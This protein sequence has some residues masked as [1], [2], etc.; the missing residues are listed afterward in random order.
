MLDDI[1][2]CVSNLGVSDTDI[3]YNLG[4][5]AGTQPVIEPNKTLVE[6]PVNADVQE[7]YNRLESLG[8]NLTELKPVLE[9]GDE[10]L[11]ISCAGS[12]KTTALI[13][14][15]IKGMISGEYMKYVDIPTMQGGVTKCLVPKKIFIGTFLKTG[16]KELENA[17][18]RWVKKLRISGLSTTS[19][20]FGTLHSEFYDALRSMG[21]GINISKDTLDLLESV[22]VKYDIHNENGYGY[23]KKS[24]NAEELRDL[25]CIITYARN[26]LDDKRYTHPL[27][28]T[29]GL[30]EPMLKLILN[31]FAALRQ[32]TNKM[33]FEDLQELLYNSMRQYPH[34]CEYLNS[35]YDVIMLDEFQDTSQIQYEILKEYM[36]NKQFFVI[37]DDDQTIYSW[38]GSD[39]EIINSR[40]EADF[41]PNVTM[42][43][44]NYRCSC[45][46]LDCVAPSIKNNT[47]RHSKVLQACKPGGSVTV[48]DNSDVNELLKEVIQVI[49]NHKTASILSRTNADLLAPA[50]LLELQGNI[51]YTLSKGVTMQNALCHNVFG[52]IPLIL[53]QRSKHFISLF[54]QVLPYNAAR[55]ATTLAGILNMPAVKDNIFTLSADDLKYSVP[56]LW[57]TLIKPLR[58]AK[59]KSDKYTY[60]IYLTVL[61][62]NGY[63]SDTTYCKKAR[64]F[65]KFV[66][67]LVDGSTVCKSL[68]L[69]ELNEMFNSVLPERIY[70]HTHTHDKVCP[71]SI[72][73]VHEA[74]GK[75][76]DSVFIWNAIDGTFPYI[77]GSH[78]ITKE[79]YD[80]ERRIFYIAMTRARDSVTLFTD[81][82]SESP[83]LIECDH[84][85]IGEVHTDN[86][87]SET[88][89]PKQRFMP[90]KQKKDLSLV[91]SIVHERIAKYLS[92]DITKDNTDSYAL[93]VKG[94]NICACMESSDVLV[95]D[96]VSAYMSYASDAKTIAEAD[97]RKFVD[98][99]FTKRG[100]DYINEQLDI[101]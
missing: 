95:V 48:Y 97:V 72:T 38:R 70:N 81:S 101:V 3:G 17:F 12:G 54:K 98:T 43:S 78:E 76:W 5:H 16:A 7:F 27:M 87:T 40:F 20:T 18:Y 37:G 83:F 25:S 65:I 55:E 21:V 41:H 28:S 14:K 4:D 1:E 79:E 73:T 88:N 33:D 30:T 2:N 34:I 90:D 85:K 47:G 93:G 49:N 39:S 60:L 59:E 8:M 86:D 80:E 45:N 35:R 89:F 71:V 22:C 32:A 42:L 74:K 100:K 11:T 77:L 15:V 44:T 13:L 96:C 75:E 56:T 84:S 63:H 51:S 99:Y 61:I 29:Y 6:T 57:G 92:E 19:I 58:D 64:E 67:S 94:F 9:S 24:L 46:I 91:T 82:K 36:K 52:G 10:N 69:Q 26:R 66:M 23:R 62:T 50:I 53:G 68:T 31:D